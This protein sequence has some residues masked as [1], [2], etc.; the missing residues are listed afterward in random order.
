MENYRIR[1]EDVGKELVR[2]AA[3]QSSQSSQC[4]QKLLDDVVQSSRQLVDLLTSM[5]SLQKEFI[6][7]AI[8][9]VVL[10]K[11]QKSFNNKV[12][13]NLGLL[14]SRV[15]LVGMHDAVWELEDNDDVERIKFEREIPYVARV[16]IER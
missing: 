4:K 14:E 5:R 6:V 8:S 7:P 12:L 10:S 11:V 13:L 15:H 3:S 9:S 16:M 2:L 1:S